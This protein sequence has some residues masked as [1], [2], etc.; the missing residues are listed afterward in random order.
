M[1]N[2]EKI[3][4]LVE[5]FNCDS[6]I[7]SMSAQTGYG[8]LMDG[9]VP[10][11]EKISSG[12]FTPRIIH[13]MYLYIDHWGG[14]SLRVYFSQKLTALSVAQSEL[15]S[16]SGFEYWVPGNN[17]PVVVKKY[18]YS[19]NYADEASLETALQ[20]TLKECARVY[21]MCCKELGG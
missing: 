10:K 11:F 9:E 3:K 16:K 12:R 15:G 1:I 4:K 8:F 17:S 5:V 14:K 21:L 6:D 20:E 7:T 18:L 19:H 13:P 2:A